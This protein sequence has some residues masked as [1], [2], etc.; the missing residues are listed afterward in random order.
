MAEGNSN[1]LKYCTTCANQLL[2]AHSFCINCGSPAQSTVEE[3][4][5]GEGEE[6]IKMYIDSGYTYDAILAFL[7]KYHGISISMSTLQRRLRSYGFS[8]RNIG[9]DN[10]EVKALIRKELDGAGCLGGYRSIWHSLRLTH[11]ISISRHTVATLMREIDPDGVEVR[12]RRRLKRR[13]YSSPGPNFVWHI[14]GYDKLKDFGFPIHGCIDGYSRK[15]LWLELSRTNNNPAVIAAFYLDCLKEL[16]GCP[17]ILSTDPG[18]ENCTMA[19]IQVRLRSE[20]TDPHASEKSHRF[21]E[22]KHNQ[23]IEAWWSFFRRSRSSWWINFFK[24]LIDK[25]HFLP[26]NELHKECLWFC[27]SNLLREDLKFVRIHWNTHYIRKSRFETIPGRPDMLFFLPEKNGCSDQLIE[28]P[29]DEIE[30]MEEHCLRISDDDNENDYQKYFA[31]VLNAE[32]L[33][34]PGTWSEALQLYLRLISVTG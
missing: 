22:S 13:E 27:F 14:D 32:D 17:V 30:A 10:D 6:L 1:S 18:S 7:A 12:K 9:V 2:E 19:A 16:G 3:D 20:C 11:S 34:C 29:C 25:G 8:R 24:D 5:Y 28:V 21:V 33:S 23:R 26:G 4:S 31:Y 15:V